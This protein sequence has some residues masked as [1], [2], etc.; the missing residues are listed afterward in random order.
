MIITGL[1]LPNSG[2]VGK[3]GSPSTRLG[4]FVPRQ[5]QAGTGDRDSE[6][7]RVDSV[8]DKDSFLHHGRGISC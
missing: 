8:S 5:L 1:G 7:P 2:A 6:G 4:A 3:T